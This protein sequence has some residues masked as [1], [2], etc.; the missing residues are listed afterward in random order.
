MRR[1]GRSRSEANHP[2]WDR[3]GTTRSPEAWASVFVHVIRHE[4]STSVTM[5]KPSARPALPSK[6]A[7]E[8]ITLAAVHNAVFCAPRPANAY[9]SIGIPIRHPTH[10]RHRPLA[11]HRLS[12]HSPGTGLPCV[13]LPTACHTGRWA[14][15]A[16]AAGPG[17]QGRKA[18]LVPRD[19]PRASAG[20]HGH[21]STAA[22]MRRRKRG[23]SPLVPL[24]NL[25]GLRALICSADAVATATRALAHVARQSAGDCCRVDPSPP[26]R[27]RR[28]YFAVKQSQ[29]G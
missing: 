3:C 20:D 4:L 25:S 29:Q 28:T 6:P 21:A 17:R 19:V 23:R 10:H 16:T 26:S 18:Q 9:P 12:R 2:A 27:P 14:Q 15:G 24:A 7:P 11:T 13:G 1:T 8:R 22:S 5:C